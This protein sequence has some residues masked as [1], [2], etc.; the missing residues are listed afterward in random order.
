MKLRDKNRVLIDDKIY[1]IVTPQEW[2]QSKSH[3]KQVMIIDRKTTFLLK[4]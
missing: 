2:Q 4:L 1:R 3:D